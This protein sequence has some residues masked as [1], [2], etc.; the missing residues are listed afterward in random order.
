M[1]KVERIMFAGPSGCGKTTLAK[2]VAELGCDVHWPFLSGSV[3]DLLPSTKDEPH[4]DMLSHDKSD[5][6]KQD[7][8]ILS[9]RRKQYANHDT[10][11]TDRSYLDSAA[12]FLYKQSDTIPQCEMEHFLELC[13]MCLCQ[14]CDHLFLI[15]FTPYMIRNW[16]ME[17][18]NKRILN[19]YF[20]AHIASIMKFILQDWGVRFRYF[21]SISGGFMKCRRLLEYGGYEEGILSTIYGYVGITII[22]EPE[23]DIRE[24]IISNV[25]NR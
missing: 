19:K 20:Q 8:Q 13:K 6:Y 10:F 25:L 18:N 9:L 12:Y 3:S 22:N 11:V 7:F 17:D 23:L 16:V 14:Q 2:Y 1:N 4:K 21:D 5:L 24:K 15:N